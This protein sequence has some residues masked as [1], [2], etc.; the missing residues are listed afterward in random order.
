MRGVGTTMVAAVVGLMVLSGC[1]SAIPGRATAEAGAASTSVPATTTTP[2]TSSEPQANTFV[3]YASTDE[4]DRAFAALVGGL[5]SWSDIAYYN[6]LTESSLAGFTERIAGWGRDFCSGF[7]PDD[8]AFALPVGD[9]DFTLD[10]GDTELFVAAAVGVFCPQ[11][12]VELIPGSGP[13]ELVDGATRCPNSSVVS[14]DLNPAGSQYRISNDSDFDAIVVVEVNITGD[15]DGWVVAVDSTELAQR[16]EAGSSIVNPNSLGLSSP[17]FRVSPDGFLPLRCQGVPGGPTTPAS[18]PVP[19]TTAVAPVES[20]P[21]VPPEVTVTGADAQ[22][23]LD[24]PGAR[25]N[26]DD[27]AVLVALTDGS[28]VSI[29]ETGAGRF[30]YRGAR[31]S[32]GASIEIDDPA[33]TDDG[34]VATNDGTTYDLS[35]SAL[36]ITTADGIQTVQPVRELWVR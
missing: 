5:D 30:Y 28:A 4:E 16:V 29:C 3:R 31:T 13:V 20:P 17:E 33:P 36:V 9:V 6:L 12:I 11:R 15:P 14:V 32:D 35:P 8:I 2:S 34:F 23:F 25:C 19:R 21:S 22:G 10:P 27:P 24:E 7:D 1:A 26:A 18:T